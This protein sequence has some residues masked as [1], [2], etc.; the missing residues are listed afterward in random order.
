MV[1]LDIN[2][3]IKKWSVFL[4][5]VTLPLKCPLWSIW[6]NWPAVT[7]TTKLTRILWPRLDDRVHLSAF[8]SHRLTGHHRNGAQSC[9]QTTESSTCLLL[10]LAGLLCLA[11]HSIHTRT[12][13]NFS[14][15][16]LSDRFFLKNRLYSCNHAPSVPP[17]IMNRDSF[18]TITQVRWMDWHRS[19]NMISRLER[20]SCALA[21]AKL[22]ALTRPIGIKQSRTGQG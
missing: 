15:A 4:L 3:L 10:Y 6:W 1:K 14:I 9:N 13:M 22:L 19:S 18:E 16:E 20:D 2:G 7:I 11:V 8:G 12:K 21:A 17:P 5:L